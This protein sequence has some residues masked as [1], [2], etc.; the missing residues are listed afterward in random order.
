MKKFFKYFLIVLVIL[1]IASSFYVYPRLGIVNGYASKMMCSCVFIANRDAQHVKDNDLN[2]SLIKYANPV[3]NKENKSVTSTI[4]GLGSQTAYYNKNIG[5]SL[6]QEEGL[7]TYKK[8]NFSKDFSYKQVDSLYWPYS[9]TLPDTIPSN[10][11]IELIKEAAS[12]HFNETEEEHNEGIYKHTRALLVIYKDQ[13]IF[14][15]YADGFNKNTPQLG[16][17]MTKSITNTMVGVMVKKGLIDIEE[18]VNIEEWKND[19]RKNITWDALL[20]MSDGLDW[21]ED[22]TTIS[23]ATKMLYRKNDM[24]KYAIKTPLSNKKEP[25]Y[26]YSSGTSNILAG[27]IKNVVGDDYLAFPYKEIFSKVGMES[28][29]I[30]TDASGK[31]VGSSY[32]WATPRDW[33]KYGLLYLHDGN[34]LGEQI[35]PKGWAKYSGTP[36]PGSES[37]YGAHFWTTNPKEFPDVPDDMYMADGYQGQRVFIIPSKDVVIVR[38]GTTLGE[39][40]SYNEMIRDVLKGIQ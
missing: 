2:Y 37:R 39:P 14:E 29:I 24:Y 35:L 1:L 28:M 22:Y 6:V 26:Y 15:Q 9:K 5:C 3:V 23:D 8:I 19:E 27:A 17:S 32:S 40:I 7:E 20:K 33:A 21:L 38:L 18:P 16:W 10:V 12:V 25:K 13:L 4:W 36:V 34:W 31:F 11:N 30:E